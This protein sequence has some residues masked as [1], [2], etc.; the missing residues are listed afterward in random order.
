M[1]GSIDKDPQW[2]WNFG[3]TFLQWPTPSY[4]DLHLP[5]YIYIVCSGFNEPLWLQNP[6]V[7]LKEIHTYIVIGTFV[8]IQCEITHLLTVF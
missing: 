1:W 4:N 5:I 3:G 2:G 6:F 7:Q 8:S